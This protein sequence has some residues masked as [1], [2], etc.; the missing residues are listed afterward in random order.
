MGLY[1]LT[2]MQ[3]I[4][5]D[6]LEGCTDR[7]RVCDEGSGQRQAVDDAAR[8]C[9]TVSWPIGIVHLRGLF[10]AES[11]FII[12]TAVETATDRFGSLLARPAY[13]A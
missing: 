2:D 7:A 3:T 11:S 13:P 4:Y 5:A 6:L 9:M 10:E 12:R 8:V 1:A